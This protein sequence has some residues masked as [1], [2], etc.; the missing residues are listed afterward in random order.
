MK[1]GAYDVPA[2]LRGG[3]RELGS[4]RVPPEIGRGA[5]A[6]GAGVASGFE[7]AAE[8]FDALPPEQSA[9]TLGAAGRA[10]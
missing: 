8:T 2:P 1:I 3:I 6:V 10:N 5:A 9:A 4:M 7:T